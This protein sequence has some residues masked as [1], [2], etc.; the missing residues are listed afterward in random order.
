MKKVAAAISM[1]ALGGML[2]GPLRSEPVAAHGKPAG[3]GGD[4]VCAKRFTDTVRQRDA[5][6][7]AR[8]LD[9]LMTYYR[10]DAVEIDPSG[11]YHEDREAITEHLGM[12]F[13]LE[14]ESVFTEQKRI[15]DGCD[16][17]L[18]VLDS[19]FTAPAIGLDQH[20]VTAQTFTYEQGRW[21]LLL[22]ANTMLPA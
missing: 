22:A 6:W 16:T 5:A 12:L 8:D 18:L 21:R 17:A 7:D 14:F 13:Q 2:V 1:L 19:R 15:V 11:A 9:K 20:F 4:R 10:P 3:H